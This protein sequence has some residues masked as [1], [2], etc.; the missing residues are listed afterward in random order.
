M[1]GDLRRGYLEKKPTARNA[2]PPPYTPRQVERPVPVDVSPAEV[3]RR[4][5][6]FKERKRGIDRDY[7]KGIPSP[8][9]II[10]RDI[11]NFRE[12]RRGGVVAAFVPGF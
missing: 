7:R 2:P 12:Q 10:K 9:E 8:E 5:R 4:A 1:L 6:E 11:R 3:E